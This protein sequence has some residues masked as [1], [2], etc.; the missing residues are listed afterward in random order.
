MIS[1]E[2]DYNLLQDKAQ[3]LESVIQELD[4]KGMRWLELSEFD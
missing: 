1:G 3:R 2:T 4:E